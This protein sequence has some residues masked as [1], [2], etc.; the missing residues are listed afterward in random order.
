MY[1]NKKDK[2]SKQ[3][4]SVLKSVYLVV[5]NLQPLHDH[6]KKDPLVKNALFSPYIFVKSILQ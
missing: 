4:F 1:S 2:H 5:F 6:I 3:N